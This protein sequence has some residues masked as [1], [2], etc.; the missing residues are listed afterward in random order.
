MS[1][2]LQKD[3]LVFLIVVFNLRY[4]NKKIKTPI[5]SKYDPGA[6]CYLREELLHTCE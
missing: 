3:R 2:Y 5:K 1:V 6:F 4:K